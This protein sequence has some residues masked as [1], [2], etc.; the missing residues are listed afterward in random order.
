MHTT[1]ESVHKNDVDN[2]IKLIYNTLLKNQ[3]RTRFSIHQI[4]NEELMKIT[5]TTQSKLQHTDFDNL[6][7]GKCF[8]DHMFSVSYK[9]EQ[10]D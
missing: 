8:S 5:K 10:M 1:V 7:F 3:R 9:N 4:I 2:V 6:S